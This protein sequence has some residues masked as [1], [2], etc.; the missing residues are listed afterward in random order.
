MQGLAENHLTQLYSWRV[1]L[2]SHAAT[3]SADPAPPQDSLTGVLPV[4]L[5][6]ISLQKWQL[7]SKRQQIGRQ[8]KIS[9]S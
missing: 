7:T 3:D 1:F 8:K 6:I 2:S 5:I 4:N 9:T